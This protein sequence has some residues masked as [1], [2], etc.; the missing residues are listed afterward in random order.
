MIKKFKS[1]LIKVLYIR[2]EI[3]SERKANYFNTEYS[4][5]ILFSCKN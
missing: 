4:I 1:I 3:L 2:E 5:S